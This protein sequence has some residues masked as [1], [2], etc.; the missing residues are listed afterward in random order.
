MTTINK[1]YLSI[2]VFI[3]LVILMT[4]FI[5]YPLFGEIKNNS[6]ELISQKESLTTLETKI[7]DLERFKILYKELEEILEK[8]DNLFIDPEVPVEFIG[9]L[10]K[11]AED[12]QLTIKISFASFKKIEKDSW[13]FLTFQTT[14]VGS[15]SNFLHFLEV[16]LRLC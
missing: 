1:I 15:F 7:V 4:V 12:C 10:E 2:F 16:F 11:T 3:A 14:S 9:F 5:I 13:P 6:K 8:I